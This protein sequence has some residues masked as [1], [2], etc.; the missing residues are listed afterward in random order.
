MAGVAP[1]GW[2]ARLLTT[3]MWACADL[4]EDA[5]AHRD[6]TQVRAGLQ[7][8]EQVEAVRADC[9]RIRS[10]SIRTSVTATVEGREW[11]AELNR[12]QGDNQPELWLAVA[13]EWD[14]FNRP[15]RAGYA[16]WRAAQALLTSVNAG[17]QCPP[18]RRRTTAAISMCR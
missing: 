1:D 5:R 12:C 14:T 15:H 16:W 6:D 4:V 11:A 2:A 3:A 17:R 18:C 8:A 10:P 9:R 7:A 13:Q